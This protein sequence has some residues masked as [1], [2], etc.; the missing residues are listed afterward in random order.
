MEIWNRYHRLRHLPWSLHRLISD[1]IMATSQGKVQK[2]QHTTLSI[3]VGTEWVGL[4]REIFKIRQ[5]SALI[6]LMYKITNHLL[7]LNTQPVDQQHI[8]IYV[9]RDTKKKRSLFQFN[10][11]MI[12]FDMKKEHAPIW[13]TR[14]PHAHIHR[15]VT[16]LRTPHSTAS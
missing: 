5:H 13:Y 3:I 15:L 7:S 10:I 2:Y 6:N 12:R 9:Y 16:D 11:Y 14:Q 4:S 1:T 8:Y